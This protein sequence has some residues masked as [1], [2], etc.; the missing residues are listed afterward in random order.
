[1]VSLVAGDERAG[2][3]GADRDQG[4]GAVWGAGKVGHVVPSLLCG[5]MGPVGARLGS[6]EA[7]HCD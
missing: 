2:G 3:G 7:Q 5:I 1:M 4:L 6:L